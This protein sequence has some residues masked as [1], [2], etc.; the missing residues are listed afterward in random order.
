[1]FSSTIFKQTLKQN[2]KLW[3]IFTALTAAIAAVFIAVFDPQLVK[4]LTD[5]IGDTAI[6]DIAGGECTAFLERGVQ[7]NDDPRPAA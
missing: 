7:R 5:S 3:A 1:M 2:W 6:A 4:T